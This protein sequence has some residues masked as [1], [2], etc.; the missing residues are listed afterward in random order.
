MSDGIESQSSAGVKTSKVCQGEA[1][2]ASVSAVPATGKQIIMGLLLCEA[3]ALWT[4]DVGYLRHITEVLSTSLPSFSLVR[5]VLWSPRSMSL[6]VNWSIAC[7]KGWLNYRITSANSTHAI[8]SVEPGDK[9]QRE[10]INW[11][12]WPC[13]EVCGSQLSFP[14][15]GKRQL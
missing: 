1:R 4:K 12:S 7:S 11:W 3:E 8:K 14:M 6:I 15:P 5:A 13:D 2:R 10:L 9:H